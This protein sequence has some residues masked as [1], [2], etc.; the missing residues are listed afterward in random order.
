MGA[1]TDVIAIA[2][3]AEIKLSGLLFFL[4]AVEGFRRIKC[5]SSSFRF[6]FEIDVGL[7]CMVIPKSH[8]ASEWSDHMSVTLW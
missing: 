7:W 8:Q 4:M 1:P 3:A 2:I 5:L 6:Y